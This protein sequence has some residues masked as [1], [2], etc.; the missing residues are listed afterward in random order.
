MPAILSPYIPFVINDSPQLSHCN[1]RSN[2]WRPSPV[3]VNQTPKSKQHWFTP[4]LLRSAWPKNHQPPTTLT[5]MSVEET[6]IW[7][8]MLTSLKGWKEAPIYARN[9]KT[10]GVAGHMLTYLTVQT[11]RSELNILKFGHRLEI[12]AAIE[13]NELTLMNPFIVSIRTNGFNITDKTPV[14]LN[15]RNMHSRKNLATVHSRNFNTC[16]SNRFSLPNN[17]WDGSL[18]KGRA[19][20]PK[21]YWANDSDFSGRQKVEETALQMLKKNSYCKMNRKSCN[22]K[23]TLEKSLSDTKYPWMPP[24]KLPPSVLNLE[25]RNRLGEIPLE[26]GQGEKVRFTSILQ[27]RRKPGHA[28]VKRKGTTCKGVFK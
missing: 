16:L 10:N 5:R 22:T 7:L 3:P 8:E 14:T 20:Q 4:E 2:L 11:L 19:L 12:V 21:A 15:E 26:F 9:F 27:Q 13:D 28:N 24:M 1:Y 23:F 6:A 17:Y 18:I 25:G